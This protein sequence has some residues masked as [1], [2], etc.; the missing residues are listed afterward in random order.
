MPL[1]L[2]PQPKKIRVQEGKWTIPSNPSIG[3]SDPALF[4]TAT[5]AKILFRSGQIHASAPGIADDVCLCVDK[6]LGREEYRLSIG[7]R[8]VTIAGGDAA[9]VFYGLQTLEQI[10]EQNPRQL[11]HLS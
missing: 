9:A 8:G 2:I 1:S 6:E 3:I 11:P 7:R 5:E 10:L 4:D